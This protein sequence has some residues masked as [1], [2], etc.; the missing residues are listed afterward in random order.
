[1]F[2]EYKMFNNKIHVKN[3]T[4]IALLIFNFNLSVIFSQSTSNSSDNFMDELENINI[5]IFVDYSVGENFFDVKEYFE[6]LNCSVTVVG[7]GASVSSCNNHGNAQLINT[8][9]RIGELMTSDI[10]QF[11]CLCI[12]SGGYWQSVSGNSEALNLI[13]T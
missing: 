4:V 3:F 7:R 11:D 9:I 12:P 5:L 10:A 2:T 8:D 13:R 6:S 1:M